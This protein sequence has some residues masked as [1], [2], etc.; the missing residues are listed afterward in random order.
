MAGPTVLIKSPDE[1]VVINAGGL[2]GTQGLT[3]PQGPQ[4]EKGEPAVWARM[5]QAEYDAL[6]VKDPQTLYVIIG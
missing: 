6:I 5:S 4:G 3:G 2:P 1:N